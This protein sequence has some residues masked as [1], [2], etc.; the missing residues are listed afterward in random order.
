MILLPLLLVLFLSRDRLLDAFKFRPGA[1]GRGWRTI[2]VRWGNDF[3]AVFR[4]L[5]SP[6]RLPP[7]LLYSIGLWIVIGLNT[8]LVLRAFHIQS[9]FMATF[10]FLPLPVLGIA[11]PTPGGV[12]SFELLCRW[13]LENLFGAPP[14]EAIAASVS[15]HFVSLVTVLLFGSASIWKEGI[16]LRG[17]TGKVSGIGKDRTATGE[18]IG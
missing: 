18:E 2:L 3:V 15:L 16:S 5:A 8:W 1:S 11:V 9:S 10:L 7:I 17:L 6:K 4:G 14:H 13:G 12:G